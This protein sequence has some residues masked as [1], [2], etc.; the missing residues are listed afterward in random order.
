MIAPVFLYKLSENPDRQFLRR[1]GFN[2]F[3]RDAWNKGLTK[4][5]DER[6]AHQVATFNSRFSQGLYKRESKPTEKAFCS[7]YKYGTYKGFYCD[8]SWELAFLIYHLDI[9]DN[10]VRNNESFDY[11]TTD[12][13]NRKFFPDFKIDNT[14]YEIKG[15]YDR[16]A[17][18]KLK[19]F[20]KELSL[21]WISLTEIQFYLDYA[22]NKFGRNFYEIYDRN[23]PSWMDK[24]ASLV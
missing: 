17:A 4:E 7:R 20:P 5:T 10:V 12:G 23:Y 22:K 13:L 2:N 1:E 21:K 11:K 9:G 16:Q 6:V 18:N 24:Y 19:D 8:S 3:G 14:F 15:G